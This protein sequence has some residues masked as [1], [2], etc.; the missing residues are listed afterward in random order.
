MNSDR[1]PGDGEDG[2]I[3]AIHELIA[4][5]SG[6]VAPGGDNSSGAPEE[7]PYSEY[8]P[9]LPGS[10]RYALQHNVDVRLFFGQ[11]GT[12]RLLPGHGLVILGVEDKDYAEIAELVARLSPD[13]GDV[14]AIESAVGVEFSPDY[15]ARRIAGNLYESYH[16]TRDESA[17]I[18]G[19][20]TG[21]PNMEEEAA[22][23]LERARKLQVI[24]T[25]IYAAGLALI[26]GVKVINADALTPESHVAQ[27]ART[28]EFYLKRDARTIERLGQEAILATGSTDPGGEPLLAMVRGSHHRKT[29]ERLLQVENVPFITEAE[30]LTRTQWLKKAVTV[31]LKGEKYEPI[32]RWLAN[33]KLNS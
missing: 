9:N 12:P 18:L 6:D 28:P 31:A 13:R 16:I 26:K 4:S 15:L 32:P 22:A 11:H 30:G 33:L 2:T 7:R 25:F 29:I 3:P 24:E 17:A 5:M 19:V 14:L 23:T 1:H 21:I 27:S 8:S 10:H 20:G